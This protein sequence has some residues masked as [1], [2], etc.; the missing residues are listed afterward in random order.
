[1]V[2]QK[3]EAT[4]NS[5]CKFMFCSNIFGCIKGTFRLDNCQVLVNK[6]KPPKYHTTIYNIAN[7]IIQIQVLPHIL[8]S[9]GSQPLLLEHEEESGTQRYPSSQGLNSQALYIKVKTA[10][11]SSTTHKIT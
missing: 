10:V 2:C 4:C 9:S 3:A 7:D 11:N 8:K 5:Y 6:C 1:M